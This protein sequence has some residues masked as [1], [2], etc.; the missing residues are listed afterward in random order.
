MIRRPLVAVSLGIVLGVLP[1][2]AAWATSPTAVLG[3][4]FERAN[5]VLRSADPARGL[6]EPRHAIRLLI[7]EVFDFRE[8]AAVAL[9]PVWTSRTPREQDEFI[10][11]FA[12]L[13]ER[14][15]IAA[16]SSKARL[17]GGISVHYMAESVAGDAA[18][19]PTRVL[20]RAGDDLPVD[21]RLAR[22]GE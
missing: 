13:L 22:R 8:A 1:S 19:V 14:G 4:F 10:Q 9:G 15:Y 21:Y 18:T 5:A 12:D 3:T 17:V 7:A 20:T 6:E 11:L 2:S 16:F